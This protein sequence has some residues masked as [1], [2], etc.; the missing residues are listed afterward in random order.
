MYWNTL[1][2]CSRTSFQNSRTLNLRRTTI[3]APVFSAVEV[4]EVAAAPWYSGRQQ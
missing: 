4:T 2:W 3:A 1:I